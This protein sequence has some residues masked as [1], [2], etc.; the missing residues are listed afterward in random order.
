[1]NF[2]H[3]NFRRAVQHAYL[4]S[5]FCDLG[6]SLRHLS[7]S[8]EQGGEM[9]NSWPQNIFKSLQRFRP[10]LSMSRCV[11]GEKKRNKK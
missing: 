11:V 3:M 1:M 9:L 5:L 8:M 2:F 10:L 7:A 6:E 4:V